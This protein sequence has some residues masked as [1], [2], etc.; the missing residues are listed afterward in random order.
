MLYDRRID[1]ALTERPCPDL[2]D[3]LPSIEVDTADTIPC[4]PKEF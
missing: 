2:V 3:T 4:P 1:Y